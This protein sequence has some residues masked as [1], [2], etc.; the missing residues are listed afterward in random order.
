MYTFFSFE[1]MLK[2]WRSPQATVISNN[3]KQNDCAFSSSSPPPWELPLGAVSVHWTQEHMQHVAWHK[4]LKAGDAMLWLISNKKKCILLENVLALTFKPLLFV[5]LPR[6]TRWKEKWTDTQ[7][8]G[9]LL[10][11][12]LRSHIYPKLQCKPIRSLEHQAVW[13][14][15]NIFTEFT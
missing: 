4:C 2:V 11:W 5:W 12:A 15:D 7:S 14:D 1:I 3:I 9:V 13:V 6:T 8:H 10:L